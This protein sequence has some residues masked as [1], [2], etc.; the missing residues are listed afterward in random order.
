MKFSKEQKKLK[1]RKTL[2]GNWNFCQFH[3]R[4]YAGSYFFIWKTKHAKFFSAE[5]SSMTGKNAWLKLKIWQ[6]YIKD[7]KNQECWL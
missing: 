5:V 7:F 6:F 1:Q 2:K 3:L 4:A